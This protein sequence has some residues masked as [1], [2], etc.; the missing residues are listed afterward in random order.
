[1]LKDLKH[2]QFML[3]SKSLKFWTS[4]REGNFTNLLCLGNGLKLDEGILTIIG[5]NFYLLCKR[6][7]DHNPKTSYTSQIKTFDID[8]ILKGNSGIVYELNTLIFPEF[9]EL[10]FLIY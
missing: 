9:W 1:M 10:E 4:F 5:G 8:E 2:E 6:N 3:F 7:L